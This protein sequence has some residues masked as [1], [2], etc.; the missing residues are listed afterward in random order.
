M[1]SST[2][3]QLKPVTVRI[4]AAII[5]APALT[6][7]TLSGPGGV[8]GV[9][10]AVVIMPGQR[11]RRHALCCTYGAARQGRG[12][13]ELYDDRPGGVVSGAVVFGLRR[14]VPHGRAGLGGVCLVLTTGLLLMLR[15]QSVAAR[16]C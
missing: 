1:G 7:L 6:L 11:S 16:R 15:V 8:L 9:Q 13:A 12:G 3:D 14:R 2:T 10:A 5:A 4:M